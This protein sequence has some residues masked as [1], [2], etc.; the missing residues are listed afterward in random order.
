MPR[1]QAAADTLIE[2][3]DDLGFLAGWGD[4]SYARAWPLGAQPGA[5]SAAAE[6]LGMRE[7]R[8]GEFLLPS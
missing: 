1:D 8:A 5:N 6:E 3:S 7:I 4:M 2:G